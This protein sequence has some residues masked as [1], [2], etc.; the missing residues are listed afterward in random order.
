MCSISEFVEVNGK[1][2]SVQKQDKIEQWDKYDYLHLS[3]VDLTNISNIQHLENIKDLRSL[4]IS[5]S[6]L[7][8]IEG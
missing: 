3:F 8:S 2:F 4:I 5:E 7:P 6:N 1:K